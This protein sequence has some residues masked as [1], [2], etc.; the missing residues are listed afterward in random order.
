MGDNSAIES[1]T[2]PLRV[3]KT[4]AARLGVT[5]AEYDQRRA[6]G[7]KWCTGCKQWH[8]RTLFTVD[9]SRSDGLAKWCLIYASVHDR[10]KYQPT[11]RPAPGR[12]FVPARSGDKEQARRRV[13]HLVDVGVL[14]D[15][16]TVPCIDCGHIHADGE[17]RHEYDHYSGY[18]AEHH[19]DVE[20]VCSRCHHTRE[21]LRR[22]AR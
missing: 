4:A 15:P 17:R 20:A 2:A 8:R 14:P 12:R 13:N 1:S 16:N 5:L 19:E 3:R 10:A 9:R 6:A 11:S 22:A 18:D 21:N 7:E